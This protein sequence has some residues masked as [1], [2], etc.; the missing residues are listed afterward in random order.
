MDLARFASRALRRRLLLPGGLWALLSS[1]AHLPPLVPFRDPLSAQEH[2]QL[3]ASY[4]AQGLRAEAS[5]QYE[6]A[7][8]RD[9]SFVEA[10]MASGNLSFEDGD[11]RRAERAYRR[12]LR[13]SPH[14]AGAS[15]NLAM[16]L[17]A[18]NR[19]LARAEQLAL[20]AFEQD[21]PLRPYILDTLANIYQRQGRR[22]EAEAAWLQAD[23]PDGQ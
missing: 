11:L 23:A 18:R 4:E 5:Q 21:G 10:W 2:A 13:L 3:G 7:L 20:D 8:R 1:C 22:A 16:V 17:L 6:A 14:H 15:N 9:P 19:D 12:V